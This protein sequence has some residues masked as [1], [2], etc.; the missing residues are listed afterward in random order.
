VTPRPEKNVDRS[1]TCIEQFKASS[2]P[3]AGFAKKLLIII[4]IKLKTKILL[5]RRKEN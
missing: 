3:A 5:K 1:S 2:D 4:S